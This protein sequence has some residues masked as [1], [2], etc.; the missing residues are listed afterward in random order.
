MQEVVC[1]VLQCGCRSKNGFCL[2]RIVSIAQNGGC[3]WIGKPGWQKPI[4]NEFKSTYDY[5]KTR[6]PVYEIPE[7]EPEEEKQ[8]KKE[9][10]ASG[11]T[12]EG[13]QCDSQ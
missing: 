9:N 7:T 8:E 3:T 11:N 12:D 10:D 6:E 13:S 5:W 2:N 4:E 1:Q